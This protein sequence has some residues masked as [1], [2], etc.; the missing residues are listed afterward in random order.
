[1]TAV[2]YMP[3]TEKGIEELKR[4]TA[5]AHAKCVE[6][7]LNKLNCPRKQKTEIIEY[8]KH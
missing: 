8:I 1:M 3:T 4:R 5:Q 2:V 6:Y 7:N